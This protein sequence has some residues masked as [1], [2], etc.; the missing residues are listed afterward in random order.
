MDKKTLGIVSIL[1]VLAIGG[2]YFYTRNDQPRL[3][4]EMP[5][6]D[7]VEE[8]DL[9]DLVDENEVRPPEE[10]VDT[11]LVN[12]IAS[13]PPSTEGASEQ[14]AA[15]L[16]EGAKLEM[17]EEPT[18]G[19]LARFVG[20]QDVPDNGYEIS[21]A[22][23][24]DNPATGAEEGLAEIEVVLDYSGIKAVKLFQLTKTE[25]GW[26]IDAVN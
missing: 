4:T 1:V 25:I 16:S 21:E 18:S 19:D 22:V 12:F 3:Q 14:A 5:Q 13:A 15:L 2:L 7:R 6:I 17:S 24:M 26:L 11:F 8:V 10:I 20:V 9:V 23:Y